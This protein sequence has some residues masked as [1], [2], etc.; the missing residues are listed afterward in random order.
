LLKKGDLATISLNICM[1]AKYNLTPAVI[2]NGQYSP[3]EDSAVALLA[4]ALGDLGLKGIKVTGS[5]ENV[6]AEQPATMVREYPQGAEIQNPQ[7]FRIISI[8]T[9]FGFD[10]PSYTLTLPA[11]WTVV[12]NRVDESDLCLIK[13]PANC[14]V[15]TVTSQYQVAQVGGVAKNVSQAYGEYTFMDTTTQDKCVFLM[16]WIVNQSRKEALSGAGWRRIDDHRMQFTGTG[17]SFVLQTAGTSIQIVERLAH[18]GAKA[19]AYS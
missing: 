13:A 12:A 17:G 8:P 5:N 18:S 11:G 15:T 14:V 2:K 19:I 6:G 3:A 9:G 1:A 10:R 4:K 7:A 16:G